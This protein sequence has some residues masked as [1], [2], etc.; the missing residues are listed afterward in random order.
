MALTAVSPAAR[1]AW[2]AGVAGLLIGAVGARLSTEAGTV[3]FF[4]NLHWTATTVSTAAL[5]W[6]A[7]RRAL[8]P[9]QRDL[10]FWMAL[11]VTGY[12]LGQV[13]WDV[14]VALDYL[15]FPAPADALYLTLGPCVAVGLVRALRHMEQ[16]ARRQ[17]A[18]LDSAIMVV[19]GLALT[20]VLYLPKRGAT[21][22]LALLTLIAY[23]MLMLVA[24][25]TM[26]AAILSLRWRITL[27]LVMLFSGLA[28]YTVVWMRWNF[29]ALD[30]QTVPGSYA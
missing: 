27:P 16:E 13:V 20:L 14:Q 28:S 21:E 4:D 8:E 23:P 30:G 11:G 15:P 29:L 19:A 24:V 7:W 10:L 9:G 17:A 5:G 25:A 6:L 2:L 18:L 3:N 22:P 12:A 26:A 1:I